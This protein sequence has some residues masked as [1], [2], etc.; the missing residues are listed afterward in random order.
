MAPA[1]DHPLEPSKLRHFATEKDESGTVWSWIAGIIAVLV[2]MTLV[3][4]YTKK[5]R[6]MVATSP[7]SSPSTSTNPD[8]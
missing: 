8:Q 6:A 7:A 2:V 4:G 3:Y 1:I 5:I